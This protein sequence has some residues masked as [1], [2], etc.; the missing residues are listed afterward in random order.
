MT[1]KRAF[2]IYGDAI[3]FTEEL[4][5]MLYKRQRIKLISVSRIVK[6]LNNPTPVLC[7]NMSPL[8]STDVHLHGNAEIRPLCLAENV[9]F[10][11]LGIY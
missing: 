5:V 2:L 10:E 9:G 1:L 6:Y 4:A 8:F 3:E 11:E 7:T